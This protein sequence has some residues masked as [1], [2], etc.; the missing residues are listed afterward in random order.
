MDMKVV[1]PEQ[2]VFISSYK[3]TAVRNDFVHAL[4]AWFDVSFTHGSQVLTLSTD[5]RKRYTHW[6]HTV[7]YLERGLPMMAGETLSGSLG[8]RKNPDHNRDLDVKISYNFEGAKFAYKGTRF[9]K[10]K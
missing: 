6:K 9:Y 2:L 8:V 7:F 5:P 3:L 1:T 10:L 4:V